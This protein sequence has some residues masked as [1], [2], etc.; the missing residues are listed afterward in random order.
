MSVFFERKFSTEKMPL[1]FEALQKQLP[2]NPKLSMLGNNIEG[3]TDYGRFTVESTPG[4]NIEVSFFPKGFLAKMAQSKI[5][6][7]FDNLLRT[8]S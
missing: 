1:L 4:D 5:E 6:P 2:G 3:L 7:N 8:L